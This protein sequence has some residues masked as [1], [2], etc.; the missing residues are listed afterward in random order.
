MYHDG[1]IPRLNMGIFCSSSG[2]AFYSSSIKGNCSVC[3]TE[4]SMWE[5]SLKSQG[6]YLCQQC[7][8]TRQKQ[9]DEMKADFLKSLES[10]SG[11]IL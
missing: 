3:H 4:P 8:N 1:D 6:K 2:Y 5:V 10:R 7:K 9:A 11:K